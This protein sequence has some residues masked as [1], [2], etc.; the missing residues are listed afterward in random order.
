[1]KTPKKYKNDIILIGVLILAGLVV[2]AVFYSQ[3]PAAAK[4]VVTV[5]G[6]VVGE[7]ALDKDEVYVLNGGTN[8][9]TIKDGT[10][11]I[12]D[13]MCPDQLCVNMGSKSISGETIVCLPNELIVTIQAN[14]GG[15][16]AIAQ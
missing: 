13:A 14:E 7:Y 8:T 6:Q 3:R 12:T 2:C 1:M 10:A 5:D 4:A 16:D 15:Y 11:T 9:L